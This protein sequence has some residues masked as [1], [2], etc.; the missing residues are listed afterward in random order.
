M[1]HKCLVIVFLLLRKQQMFDQWHGI[2]LSCVYERPRC[3]LLDFSV[4]PDNN[5]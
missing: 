5:T 4:Q 2:V 1:V 3:I